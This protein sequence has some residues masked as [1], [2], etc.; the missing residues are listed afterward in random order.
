[1]GIGIAP[2]ITKQRLMINVAARIDVEVSG[3]GQPHGQHTGS[4]RKISRMSGG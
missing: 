4:Q 1:M 2:D 3:L